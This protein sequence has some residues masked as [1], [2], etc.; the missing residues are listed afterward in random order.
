MI[1]GQPLLTPNLIQISFGD[2]LL[3]KGEKFP[4]LNVP[5]LVLFYSYL[6]RR[7]FRDALPYGF[8]LTLCALNG[9]VLDP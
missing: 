2:I 8:I 4:G 3:P 5:L 7:E 1:R 6:P 9:G